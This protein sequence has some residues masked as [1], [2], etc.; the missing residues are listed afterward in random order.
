M[1]DVIEGELKKRHL[2][3]LAFVFVWALFALGYMWD[4]GFLKPAI[5]GLA[6]LGSRPMILP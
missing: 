4:A 6:S 1:D 3:M 2:L 5:S